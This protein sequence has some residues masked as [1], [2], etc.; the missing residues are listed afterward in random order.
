MSLHCNDDRQRDPPILDPTCQQVID[1]LVEYVAGELDPLTTQALQEHFRDCE[2]CLAFVRTYQT[3]I[4]LTRSYR[5]E[6][7]PLLVRDRV[8]AVLRKRLPNG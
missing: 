7:L 1:L 4:R 2:D 5:Y 6:D 3:T 8:L